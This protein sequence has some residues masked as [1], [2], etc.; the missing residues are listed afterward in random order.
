MINNRF[1]SFNLMKYLFVILTSAQICFNTNANP[2]I[3]PPD[4]DTIFDYSFLRVVSTINN[5]IKSLF[6]GKNKKFINHSQINRDDIKML[7]ISCKDDYECR[8]KK[9]S[10]LNKLK[11]ELESLECFHT[12]LCLQILEV[13]KNDIWVKNENPKHIFKINYQNV[14]Y[15]ISR[16]ISFFIYGKFVVNPCQYDLAMCIIDVTRLQQ[17]KKDTL[18][19][20]LTHLSNSALLSSMNEFCDNCKKNNEFLKSIIS[21]KCNTLE[22]KSIQFFI[23]ENVKN[24]VKNIFL[25]TN[26]PCVI[27]MTNISHDF[28]YKAVSKKEVA[29]DKEYEN[30]KKDFL[31]SLKLIKSD[32]ET[33]RINSIYYG[34]SESFL[35]ERKKHLSACHFYRVCK[36]LQT[37]S[38]E[39]ILRVVMRIP[40]E[41][42]EVSET[43]NTI[44]THY[45]NTFKYGKVNEKKAKTLFEKRMDIQIIQCG[46]FI[47]ENL[48]FL[49]AQPDGLVEKDGIV[50][51][52]CPFNAKEMTPENAIKHKVIKY[53]Y[54][55]KNGDLLLKR[56]SEIF[57]Q[58][59]GELHITQRQYCYL[60]IWTPKGIV[61]S[62][63]LRDDNFWNHN[64]KNKLIDFYENIMLPE[65]INPQIFKNLNISD[66]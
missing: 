54:Y 22:G 34:N 35:K 20:S 52:K 37:S 30:K 39:A 45:R 43:E 15:Y 33:L 23:Q 38:K 32:I 28:I 41:K 17:Q 65:I 6:Y 59:Q 7:S 2:E 66:I 3:Q 13:F 57:Y 51:I 14:S 4:Y 42:S 56:T 49:A 26:I 9:K 36:F 44:S 27:E 10:S 12:F 29:M 63:I 18:D 50:E 8:Q 40:I 19:V 47:D 21:F 53:V 55:D 61:Y 24:Y 60:I 1:N 46:I 64:M 62:T 11:K 48:N 58:I 5:D 25:I 31:Q 16:M